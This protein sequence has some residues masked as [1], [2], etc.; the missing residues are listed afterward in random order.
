MSELKISNPAETEPADENMFVRPIDLNI[1]F[2]DYFR[3]KFEAV[4]R[5]MLMS[6]YVKEMLDDEEYVMTLDPETLSL[7]R[8]LSSFVDD[9]DYYIIWGGDGFWRIRHS[10]KSV[11]K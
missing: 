1:T 2:S 8:K 4:N 6:Q 10:K 5:G 7:M 3:L 11:R 9:I